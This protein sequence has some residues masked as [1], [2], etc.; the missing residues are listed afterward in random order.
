MITPSESEQPSTYFVQNRAN[1]EELHRLQIQDHLLTTAMGG[2]LPEQSDPSVFHSILDVGCGTG[3]WLIEVAQTIP[4]ATRL[5]GVDVSET[6]IEYA[7][8]QAKAA[9][10]SDRV[11]FHMMNALQ[12][13]EFPIRFFDL[14]N[15]RIGSSWLRTR[16]WPDLLREY[17]RVGRPGAVV[18][19]TESEVPWRSESA[20][21]SSLRKIAIQAF[22]QAGHLFTPV[23]EG[24]TGELAHLLQEHGLQGVQTRDT[25][26]E[27]RPGTPEGQGFFEDSRLAYRTILP[28]LR[29]RTQ[30]PENYE[31][32]C[33][34]ALSDMQ[35]PDFVATW[36]LRTAWGT[37]GN[38]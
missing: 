35:Q 27:Y 37:M 1:W 9:G 8:A 6:F 24:I 7:R 2:V 16:D 21:M 4:T 28:F 23:G 10:V 13:L 17:Q 29:K 36:P 33:E 26:I 31:Q 5:I 19:V 12:K 22:Y 25:V 20:V 15:H 11:E 38:P 30:V 18:R 34:Q 3:A 14:I 32:L